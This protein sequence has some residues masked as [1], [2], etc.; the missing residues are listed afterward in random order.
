M[1]AEH[2]WREN[3]PGIINGHPKGPHSNWDGSLHPDIFM[4]LLESGTVVLTPT[5]KNYKVY[6]EGYDPELDSQLGSTTFR[7]K[8]YFEHLSAAQQERFVEL[9]REDKIKYAYPGYFYNLPSFVKI[10]PA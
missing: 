3:K 7:D 5:D 8:F 6:I 4:R 2:G 1:S 9:M 10:S